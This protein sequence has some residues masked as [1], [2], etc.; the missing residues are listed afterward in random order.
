MSTLAFFLLYRII[1]HRHVPWRHALLG[2]AVAA[3]LFESAKQIFSYYVHAAPTYNLVYGAFAAVPLFLIWIYLSWLVILL[4]AEIT[5]AAAYWRGARW[6]QAEAPTT[7]FR[8][9]AAVMRALIEAGSAT[10]SFEDL[11]QR[12]RIPAHDLEDTLERMTTE[13]VLMKRDGRAGYRLI[14]PR[15]AAPATPAVKKAKRGRA[16]SGRSSR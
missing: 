4:G 9:A 16:R 11:H 1:P 12:T 7:R 6:K 14:E 10:V 5:A 15:G 3:F 8:E 13:G 2:G